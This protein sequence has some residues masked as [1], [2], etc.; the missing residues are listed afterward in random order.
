[1]LYQDPNGNR[2]EVVSAQAEPSAIPLPAV[3][4]SSS[5]ALEVKV[6]QLERM[7]QEKE[8]TIA[9]LRSIIDSRD[10]PAEYNSNSQFSGTIN[11]AE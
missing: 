7:V 8:R 1:M 5:A 3:N 11:A 4:N 9:E 10:Q 6:A 2:S